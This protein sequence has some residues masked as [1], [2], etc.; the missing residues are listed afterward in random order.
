MRKEKKRRVTN[1]PDVNVGNLL[2]KNIS[3]KDYE[4]E[5]VGKT[6]HFRKRPKEK[7][8]KKCQKSFNNS[9]KKQGKN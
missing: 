1:E 4:N 7:K 6:M 5:T 2:R 3:N 8:K 9:P